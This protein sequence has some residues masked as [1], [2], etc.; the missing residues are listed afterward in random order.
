MD[1]LDEMAGAVIAEP[2]HARIIV[3]LGGNGGQHLLD[4][5]PAILGAANHDRRSMTGTFFAAGNAH[6][7]KGQAAV[8]QIV[9][10]ADRIAEIRIARIDHDVAVRKM[11]FKDFHLLVDRVTSLDHDDDRARRTNGGDEFLDGFARDQLSLQ[12]PGFSVEFFRRFRGS[13]E[14]GNL[15]ALFRDVQRQVRAHDAETDQTDFCLF[16]GCAS[17]LLLGGRVVAL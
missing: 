15:V 8:L 6:A 14:Y 11:G 13:V 3:V 12:V 1:R 2:C 7:D 9:E 4:A 17:I 5:L 16:H 10:T